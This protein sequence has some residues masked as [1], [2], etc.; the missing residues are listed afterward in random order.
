M[1]PAHTNT[2]YFRLE[3]NDLKYTFKTAGVKIDVKDNFPAPTLTPST[4][5][6]KDGDSVSLTCSAP[7]PCLSN[8][9]NLTWTPTLGSS[10]ETLQ[11]NQ[12][13]TLVKTS[14]LN[15]TASYLHDGEKISCTSVYKKQDGNPDASFSTEWI[16]NG[17]PVNQSG[18]A[19]TIRDSRNG[20]YLRSI[21]T[22]NQSQERNISSLLCFSFNSLGSDS[23][24]LFIMFSQ[25]SEN[26]V[27][28]KILPSSSCTE[29]ANQINCS[30]EIMGNPPLLLWIFNG[31]PVNQSGKDFA[32]IPPKILPSS[33]CTK[34]P[35]QINCSCEIMGNPP[36]LQWI[37]NGQPIDKS[38]KVF[39]IRDSKNGTYLRSIITI[40]QSQERNISSLLCFSFN[41]L[42]SDS[43]QLFIRSSQISGDTQVP[44]K[45][46]P[47]SSCTKT[48]NHI[49][50]SCETIGSP[51][52][53]LWI[54]NGK[55]VNQSGK[56]F[57]I[58]A[59]SDS[60]NNTY[61][62]SIITLN[63]SQTR[64]MSS[65]LCL[66]FNSLGSDSKQLFIRT[67]QNAAEL[68]DKKQ[69]PLL[70]G[71]TVILLVLVCVLLFVIRFQKSHRFWEI[72]TLER[73][74]TKVQN[75]A[76]DIASS[77]IKLKDNGIAHSG[78]GGAE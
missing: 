50:C 55:P 74:R 35:N 28:P 62:R 11:E 24:Q 18:K 48:A 52:I 10:Q 59:I 16:F 25:I 27:P 78:Y 56:D 34:T 37:F 4:L 49:N 46:L 72:K 7:A 64:N 36:M 47:S 76:E 9:P 57:V 77:T 14:V 20:T 53:F 22:F 60:K 75:T 21:I 5:E 6:V 63:E 17:Q 29:T 67:L 8:P 2:Y 41:S 26:Q 39:T 15:F 40:N 12:D 54:F 3:C 38:G 1:Q 58:S 32:I 69:T 23:K 68:Q 33:S 70:I 71:T 13:K 43:K 31:Q 45:I 66:S 42:G 44:P 30:C 51:P 61:L 73:K 19:F 65:L